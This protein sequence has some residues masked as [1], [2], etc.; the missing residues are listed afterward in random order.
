GRNRPELVMARGQL[1]TL[2][3]CIQRL[4]DPGSRGRTDAQLL[5]CFVVEKDN[6]AL[7]ELVWRHGP[8]VYNVCRRVL[9]HPHNI[10]D[11][12][13]ATFL[14]LVRKAATIRNGAT[15]GGWLHQVAQ[16]VA[17]RARAARRHLE[18]LPDIAAPEDSLIDCELRP[19]LDEEVQRLPAKY[20]DA[21]VLFYLS[22]QTI[23][24]AARQL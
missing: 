10:E 3:Q 4:A 9:Q 8:L 14:I 5:E 15:I 11:A 23:K 13:Q 22:G 1:R 2:L 21:V 19:V 20:R 7:E 24:E 18:A 6:A 17:L 16:R 12:F